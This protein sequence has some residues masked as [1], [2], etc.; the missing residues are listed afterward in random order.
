MATGTHTSQAG[1]SRLSSRRCLY[2]LVGAVTAIAG[3]ALAGGAVLWSN[4]SEDL[5]KPLNPQV[6]YGGVQMTADT[7]E[8]TI[9]NLR[10]ERPGEEVTV[11]EVTA[12]TSPNV[13]YLGA[14]TIWPR[15]FPTNKL[16]AGPGFPPERM[17]DRHA[18]GEGAS[19]VETAFVP[20]GDTDGQPPP[21]AVAAGF[22]LASGDVGAVNG[23]Q[24]VYKVGDETVREVFREAAIVCLPSC[25]SRPDFAEAD[26]NERILRQLGLLPKES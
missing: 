8:F 15:D 13:E 1:P 3:L 20:P 9:G 5:L 19:A 21:L 14:F 6:T 16:V 4:D 2:R 10:I 24:V 26:F 25:E 23:V 11:L 18:L 7:Q 12:L 22:R 17:K